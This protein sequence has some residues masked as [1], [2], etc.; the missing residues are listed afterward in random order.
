MWG[1]NNDRG[2]ILFSLLSNYPISSRLSRLL[3][4]HERIS[5]FSAKSVAVNLVN[6]TFHNHIT[7]C[8]MINVSSR[9]VHDSILKSTHQHVKEAII[10]ALSLFF[11]FLFFSFLFFSLICSSFCLEDITRHPAISSLY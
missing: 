1:V 8:I 5:D 6:N 3:S 4:A 9:F 2:I 7:I 11:S 10:Q